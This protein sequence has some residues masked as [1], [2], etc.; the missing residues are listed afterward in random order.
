MNGKIG[1][2]LIQMEFAFSLSSGVYLTG[3]VKIFSEDGDLQTVRRYKE[4][5]LMARWPHII[6]MVRRHSQ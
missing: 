4:G 5:L 3:E 2:K 1:Q 6:Q